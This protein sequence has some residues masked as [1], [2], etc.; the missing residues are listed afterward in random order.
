MGID[1]QN[2][3]EEYK[4]EFCQPRTIDQNRARTLQ[5]M[6]RKEQQ[7][8]LLL[9]QSQQS[10]G[11]P[12]DPNLSQ[13]GNSQLN[14]FSTIVANKKKGTLSTKGRKGDLFG[15]GSSSNNKRKRSDLNRTFRYIDYDYDIS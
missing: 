6:K 5:L 2:I 10:S 11:L 13:S 7:N 12:I 14:T 3:P 4:C 8:F 9:K 15:A 1:R